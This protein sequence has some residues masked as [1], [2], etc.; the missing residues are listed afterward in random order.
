MEKSDRR[1]IRCPRLGGEVFFQYCE[2]EGGDLPCSRIITCWRAFLPVEDYLRGKLP[3]EAWVRFTS[4]A[5]KDKVT[6][7]LELVERAKKLT[8]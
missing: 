4:H 1:E 6:T 5:V 2:R 8:P 7:L 3:E